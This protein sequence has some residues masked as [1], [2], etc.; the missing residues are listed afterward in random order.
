MKLKT[1]HLLTGTELSAHEIQNL[2]DLAILLKRKRHLGQ[3][4]PLAGKQL[5]MIFDK[6]SLRTRM[7]FT[8]AMNELG[9][10][11]IESLSSNRKKEWPE[12]LARVLN[13]YCHAVMVRTF[14]DDFLTRMAE[15]STVPIINGLTE[16]HHPCQILADLMTL[17]EVFGELKHLTI[18]YIGDG[19]NILHSLLLLAPMV[20]VRVQYACPQAYTP[21][22]QI[23][24]MA[25]EK[26]PGLIAAYSSPEEAVQGA[27]AVYTD[28]WTSMGHEEE[29]QAR[30]AAFQGYQV[31][32]ELMKKAQNGAV[33]M[34]CLPMERGQEVSL[35]LPDSPCSVIFRQSENRLHI[36]KAILLGLIK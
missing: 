14:E 13:G 18:T 28:V 6:Q 26:C 23:V 34:H 2:I 21:T 16:L 12:D 5:A 17:Q 15:V 36:Q 29:T 19:N 30:L 27:H 31:N 25:Q 24:S 8:I 35:A 11:T 32:E 1:P 3:Y 7:S 4:Q 33:F 9:G 10:N 22:P 20:G